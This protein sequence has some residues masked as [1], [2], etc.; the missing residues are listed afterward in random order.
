MGAQLTAGAPD[1]IAGFMALAD[2]DEALVTD[3]AWSERQHVEQRLAD[4]TEHDEVASRLF[5]RL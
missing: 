5:I 2:H 3:R 1:R 4:P